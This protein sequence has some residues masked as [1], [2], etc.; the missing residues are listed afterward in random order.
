MENDDDVRI[1]KKELRG[2]FDHIQR[3][4]QEIAAI[5]KPGSAEDRFVSMSDQLD[6]IVDNTESATNTIMENAESV[7]EIFLAVRS[8]IQDATV[9]A[10]LDQIPDLISGIFEAC[11]FQ[12]ITG[13]RITKVVKTLQ[14]IERRVNALITIWGEEGLTTAEPPTDTVPPPDTDHKLLE[15]PQLKGHG[16]TQTEVDALLGGTT[17][18]TLSPAGGT[19]SQTDI[20]ALFDEGPAA[21]AAPTAPA[22]PA[23][24]PDQTPAATTPAKPAS[25][26]ASKTAAKPP[27]TDKKASDGDAEDGGGMGQD[28]IDKLF[29]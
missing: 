14:Y 17:T 25:K 1:L 15:G 24:D 2:L 8:E 23:A 22:A 20:D 27:A 16:V 26:T 13:Q 10:R 11:S 4:R 5:R 18:S 12:D 29:G 28:D 19:A 9:S 21:P 6:A 7:D 3:I